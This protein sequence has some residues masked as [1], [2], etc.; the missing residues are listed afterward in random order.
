MIYF[1]SF[2]INFILIDLFYHFFFAIIH[3]NSILS[4][5]FYLLYLYIHLFD[6]HRSIFDDNHLLS[7]ILFN[8]SSMLLYLLISQSILKK[9]IHFYNYPI[10][11]STNFQIIFIFSFIILIYYLITIFALICKHQ[12]YLTV[13]CLSLMLKIIII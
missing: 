4:H 11:I 10:L 8:L 12:S 5:S 9:M 7:I 3:L 1:F 13:I 6:S 2:I